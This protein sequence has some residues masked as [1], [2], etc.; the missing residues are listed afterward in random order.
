MNYRIYKK[1]LLIFSILFLMNHTLYSQDEDNMWVVGIGVNVV[2]IRTPDDIVGIFKDYANGTIEDLNMNG[3]F[4]RAFAGRYI[5]NGISVQISASANTIK[6]GFRYNNGDPLID[7]S[8]FAMDAKLKYDLN[9]FFGETAWFDPFVLA[10]G[11]YSK[12]G[13]TNNYNVA[14]GWGFNLWFSRT[15]GVNFQSDYN[16]HFEST[17]TDYFQHSI[18]LVFR[19]NSSPRF[20]WKGKR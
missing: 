20:K 11:G 16:H 13:D 4:V 5:K 17:A 9:R 3:G 18:G 10:G 12:I 6:K 7:D 19:L 2:D 14:A 8:F 1:I 15:V